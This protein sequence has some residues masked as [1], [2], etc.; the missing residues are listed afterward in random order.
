MLQNP[1]LYFEQAGWIAS[2]VASESYRQLYHLTLGKATTLMQ[3]LGCAPSKSVVQIQAAQD[4]IV[5]PGNRGR[6][7]HKLGVSSLGIT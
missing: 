5:L 7:Q 3:L 2:V 4:C 6:I 1:N